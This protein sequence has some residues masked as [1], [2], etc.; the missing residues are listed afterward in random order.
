MLVFF[1]YCNKS[2]FIG[3]CVATISFEE[4]VPRLE[5]ATDY[6]IFACFRFFKAKSRALAFVFATLRPNENALCWRFVATFLSKKFVPSIESAIGCC[7]FARFQNKFEKHR[8]FACFFS[9]CN[10]SHFIGVCVATISFEEICSKYSI[11]HRLLYFCL[12]L[13]FV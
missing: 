13:K 8:L 4:Y 11:S 6:G 5:T 10:K 7:A 2:H 1:S 9:I 12:F 3:D